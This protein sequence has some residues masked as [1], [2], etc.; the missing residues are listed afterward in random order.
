MTTFPSV[1]GKALIS[2]LAQAGFIVTRVKV[3]ITSFV[4]QMGGPRSSR[5][6]LA[7][8]LVP[9]CYPRFFAIAN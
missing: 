1:T 3:A 4:M 2:A 9:A 6:T 5:S 8:Q 7:K